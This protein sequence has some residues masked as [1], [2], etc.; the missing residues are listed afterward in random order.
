MGDDL[1]LLITEPEKLPTFSHKRLMAVMAVLIVAGA[2]TGTVFANYRF[3]IGVLIGGGMSYVNYFWQRRS[4]FSLFERVASGGRSSFL[5]AIYLLRYLVIGLFISFFYFTD[6]LPVTATILGL[7]AFALAV[8]VE[9][10]IGIFRS[11][12]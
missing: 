9:G 4:T 12:Y 11:S 3:G 6:L 10:M 8:V 1:D 7:A 2:V 5:A